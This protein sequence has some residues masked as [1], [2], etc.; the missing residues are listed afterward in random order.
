VGSTE[1]DQSIFLFAAF[2]LAVASFHGPY[3]TR[4]ILGLALGSGLTRVAWAG[5]H[6]DKWTEAPWSLVD[7]T[8][9]FCVL[10]LPLGF[11][12]VAPYG[13][14]PWFAQAYRASAARAL[15]PALAMSRIGCCWVG[16]CG[17]LVS[18]VGF[19]HS[20]AGYEVLA[21]TV[22]A[23]ALRR[24]SDA[25][26]PGLFLFAFG[27][28]RLLLEPLRA[29]PPLGEP[30]VEIGLIASLWMGVGLISVYLDHRMRVRWSL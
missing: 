16:C 27:A 2:W 11:L 14:S 17:G 12:L 30:G 3:G 4:F 8:G 6:F 26:A 19:T 21:W 24:V 1:I 9:G 7:A 13:A 28:L 29:T 10:A 5:L 15:A 18:G 20:V 23:L 22:L 25:Q